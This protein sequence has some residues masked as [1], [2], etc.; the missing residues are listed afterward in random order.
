LVNVLKSPIFPKIDFL[1]LEGLNKAFSKGIIIGVS[2]TSHAD[3]K[4]MILQPLDI[5]P[6]G[7]LNPLIRVVDAA[8]GRVP[9]R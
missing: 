8:L 3:L 2:S 5:F 4:M 7:I 1:T 6:R 9:L